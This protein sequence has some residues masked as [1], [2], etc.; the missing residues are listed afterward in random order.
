M[1]ISY[2]W[3]KEFVNF[4]ISAQELSEKLISL[5]FAVTSIEEIE[6]DIILDVEVTANRGDC[7]S[8]IGLAREISASLDIPLK[9]PKIEICQNNER[10]ENFLKVEIKDKFL[11][12]RYTARMIEGVKVGPSPLWM[13][14]RLELLGSRSI[15]NIVDA[16]NYIL[17]LTGQ[18]LHAFDYSMIEGQKIIVRR[19]EQGERIVTLDGVERKLDNKML[20]IADAGR[21]IALAGVMGGANTEVNNRTR[22]L[23]IESACFNAGNIRKTSLSLGLSTSASYRFE[24]NSDIEEARLSVDRVCVL[25][26]E[27]AGGTILKGLIDEYPSPCKSIKIKVRFSRI[28]QI[29]GI[30]VP[31]KEVLRILKHLGFNVKSK[32]TFLEVEVP[33]WRY[34]DVTKEI[35]VIEEI[36]R[37]Y[38]YDR[39]NLALPALELEDNKKYSSVGSGSLDIQDEVRHAMRD[40]GFFEVV[41]YGII[42]DGIFKNIFSDSDNLVKI[43]NPLDEGMDTLRPSLVHGLVENLVFNFNRDVNSLKIFE[44]GCIFKKSDVKL[45]REQVVLSALIS[46]SSHKSWVE[47]IRK[48]DFYDLKG[49]LEYLFERLGIISFKF[50]P[51]IEDSY[52]NLL[53]DEELVIFVNNKKIGFIGKLKNEILQFYKLSEDI[54]FFEIEL[55]RIKDFK[56]PEKKYKPLSKFP[57]ISRD[58]AL[59]VPVCI[60]AQEVKDLIEKEGGNLLAGVFLFDHYQGDQVPRGY[61]SLAFNLVYQSKE[62]TLIDKEVNDLH[63]SIIQRLSEK[64][65]KLRE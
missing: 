61:K 64:G 26:Q 63:F 25:I 10:I 47:K 57:S 58:A 21:A 39:I 4:R 49:V 3:L 5:G 35:D 17:L 53:T 31:K 27:I 33:S 56:K 60:S 29:L 24:R 8:I 28:N 41:N 20:V 46:G 55:E 23:V 22:N 52:K 30:D 7:L 14:R 37:L 65:I 1:K 19:A 15:N 45:P 2:K 59:L 16:T 50:E 12:P 34:A 54:Y 6:E 36:A 62:R 32:D 44:I 40:A 9:I 38:G 43:S 13:S 18:P 42:K 48:L 11:C 51:H